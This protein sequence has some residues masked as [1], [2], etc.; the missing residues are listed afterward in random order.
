MDI[1]KKRGEVGRSQQ[2]RHAVLL[3]LDADDE[4]KLR[5]MVDK[6]QTSQADVLRQC[7]RYVY[8][9]EFGRESVKPTP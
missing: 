2:K 1:L 8:G 3:E 7:L 6:T 4:T 5:E 9:I